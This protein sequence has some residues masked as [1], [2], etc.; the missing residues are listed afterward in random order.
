MIHWLNPTCLSIVHIWIRHF[1]LEN[2]WK[3]QPFFNLETPP[4]V[5]MWAMWAMVIFRADGQQVEW[6]R[7]ASFQ[8]VNALS[9]NLNYVNLWKCTFH[10]F[11]DTVCLVDFHIF[12]GRNPY[13]SR[14][15]NVIFDQR[16][17]WSGQRFSLGANLSLG[18]PTVENSILS[19]A[20]VQDPAS[21]SVGVVVFLEICAEATRLTQGRF[22]AVVSLFFPW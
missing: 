11:W 14:V 3:S 12:Y 13:S 6:N 17:N 22:S 16:V 9:M 8:S 21:C 7:V 19:G 20:H 10:H 4:C 15:C 1:C 2:P 5:A 18:V